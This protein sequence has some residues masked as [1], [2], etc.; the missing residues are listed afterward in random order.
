VPWCGGR[1]LWIALALL[2]PSHVWA[3][4]ASAHVTVVP[5]E[6][7]IGEHALINLKVITPQG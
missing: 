4:R 7:E 5:T 1:M 3:Q 6:I 2:Y